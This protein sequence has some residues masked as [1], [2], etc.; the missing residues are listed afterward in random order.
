MTVGQ[1]IKAARKKAGMTQS[2][3]G[4]LLGLSRPSVAKWENDR[5]EPRYGTLQRIATA[6]GID[7]SELISGEEQCDFEVDNNDTK[8]LLEVKNG[9]NG[10]RCVLGGVDISGVVQ[11]LDIKYMGELAEVHLDLIVPA[12][13]MHTCTDE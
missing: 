4:Q 1:R 12:S 7:W 6:L 11:G 8:I 5:C 10:F 13:Y 3:L 9:P 2:E